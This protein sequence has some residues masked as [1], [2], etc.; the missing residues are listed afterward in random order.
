[1]VDINSKKVIDLLPSRE[2]E[3][4]ANWLKEYK[5]IKYVSR[6]GS[7]TYASA[8]S[9]AH[10]NAV[11]ISD[12]FH[13]IKNLTESAVMYFQKIFSGRIQIPATAKGKKL[14]NIFNKDSDKS[15]KIK[16]IKEMYENGKT[17]N[18]IQK[19]TGCGIRTIRKYIKM[20]EKEILSQN[21]KT[22][23]AKQHDEAVKKVK[24]KAD[25]V[26][27][28]KEE[29]YSNYQIHK[30][31]GYSQ[32]MIRQYVSENFNPENAHYGQ[33]RH[34][35]LSP[36]REE[37]L[38][39]RSEG[40]KYKDIFKILVER[41]Y[42]GTEAAIRGFISHEKSIAKSDQPEE[43]ETIER[44][45]L[46]S[47][48]FRDISKLKGITEE[49]LNSFISKYPFAKQVY[50]AVATFKEIMF[51]KKT[52]ELST[53]IEKTKALNIEEFNKFINGISKDIEAVKQ[54]FILDYNNGLAEGSVNKIKLAKRI[55]YGRNDFE[56]LRKKVLIAEKIK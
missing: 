29:G 1:M 36:Y 37:I 53:W 43:T 35:K 4:V 33:R 55:M 38:L 3:D 44:K 6:D 40:K 27:K 23:R 2:A 18:E 20:N 54:A 14:R 13:I 7:L 32:T 11:Q 31:T 8:I 30:E 34:G 15:K 28:L 49:Q 25:R 5:N 19:I 16:L 24:A 22:T 46:T 52:E 41:G 39:W 47:L 45:W 48:F 26:K 21:K 51:S 10:P 42:K 17:T 9:K 50:E 56:L 12:R